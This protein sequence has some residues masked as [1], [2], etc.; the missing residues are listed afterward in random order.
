M[1]ACSVN[2]CSAPVKSEN[3]CQLH[4]AVE[5]YVETPNVD[6]AHLLLARLAYVGPDSDVGQS[7]SDD[8]G[9]GPA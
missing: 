5:Q 9:W 3:L 2:Y 7:T 6:D 4:W 1:T 8:S